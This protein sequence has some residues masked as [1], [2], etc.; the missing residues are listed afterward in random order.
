MVEAVEVTE[1]LR[2]E[3]AAEWDHLLNKT[4][5]TPMAVE[6]LAQFVAAKLAAAR[7]IIMAEAAGIA[8][9]AVGDSGD[10]G[11]WDSGYDCAAR[12]IA[13]AIRHAATPADPHEGGE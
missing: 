13:Q 6:H 3:C 8:E 12:D 11:P 9:E 4:F 10:T 2:R 7:P 1:E 5:S